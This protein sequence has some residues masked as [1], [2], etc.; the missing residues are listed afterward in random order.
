MGYRYVTSAGAEGAGVERDRRLIVYGGDE[1]KITPGMQGYIDK[2]NDYL[3]KRSAY[4]RDVVKKW[5]FDTIAVH[6][7]YSVEDAIEDYQG[8]IIEP[9]FMSS[10]Q[11]YRDSDEMACALGYMIPTWCYSRIANPSTYY[12][13]W[14]LALLEGYGFEGETSACSTSSG[15]AAIAAARSAGREWLSADEATQVLEAYGFPVAPHREVASA[16]EAIASAQELGY[17]VVL[18][19]VSERILH[20]TDVGGV[21]V[22]LR[23]ADEVGSAYR[24][25]VSRLKKRDRAFRVAVQPMVAGG[26]EVILG[27]SRDGQFGPG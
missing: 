5:K 14:T 6:G 15:M 11:A 2:N 24:D 25:L 19:A 8:A 21:K 23:N 18:K 10:S 13:E 27:V 4:I 1:I 26:R 22:D 3:A 17:P 20:K 9:V 16:A 7:L 12:Y